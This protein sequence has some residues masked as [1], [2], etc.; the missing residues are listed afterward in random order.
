M[1]VAKPWVL[2]VWLIAVGVEAAQADTCLA[3]ENLVKLDAAYE[4]ALQKGDAQFLEKLL[5]ADFIWV[6]NLASQKETKEQLLTRIK[7]LED[8]PKSR[9][10]HDLSLQ[11]LGKTV[12]LQGLSSVEKWNPDGQTFRTSRYQFMR[13]YVEHRGECK[14][15][16]IQ[17]MKVWSSDGQL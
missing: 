14:L 12:V 9:R 5:A 2:A 8:Q 1:I 7:N 13:T 15:L 16:A 10:A 11:R 6:H 17:T 4:N 3:P